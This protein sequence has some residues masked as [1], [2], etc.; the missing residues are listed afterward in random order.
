MMGRIGGDD[1]DDGDGPA[2]SSR[3]CNNPR[4]GEEK[5]YYCIRLAYYTSYFCYYY[6]S[7]VI[8]YEV[9]IIL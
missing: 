8:L 2:N 4:K 1:N 9:I 6:Y 7:E 3:Y 5:I